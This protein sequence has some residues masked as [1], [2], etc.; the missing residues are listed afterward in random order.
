MH[1]GKVSVDRTF[2]LNGQALPSSD[3]C[4]DLGVIILHPLLLLLTKE[5]I[6]YIVLSF[7]VT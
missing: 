1:I 4:K 6:S 5:L 3:T 2:S 7:L